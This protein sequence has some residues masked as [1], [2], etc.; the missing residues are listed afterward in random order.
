MQWRMSP[1]RAL[2][3]TS[4][5]M[6]FP[7]AWAME[8]ATSVTVRS[9]PLPMLKTPPS[10]WGLSS[11]NTKASATSCTWTKSRRWA[12]S[13][14]IIGRCPLERREEKIASTPVYGFESACPGP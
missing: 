13:S 14:K 8:A 4:G 3:V 12:P 1:V 11:D 9:S 2:P 5:S 7:M 6:S 10:A